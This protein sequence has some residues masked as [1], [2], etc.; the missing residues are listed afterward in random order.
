MQNSEHDTYL[1]LLTNLDYL[2]LSQIAGELP[3][4]MDR[5]NR[6]EITTLDALHL[7][8]KKQAEY[9][10]LSSVTNKI[11]TAGFP[12]QRELKDFDFSFQPMVNKSQMY[13]LATLDFME[14]AENV[15]FIGSPGVGKTHLATALG[16]EAA[17]KGF[18]TYF[19]KAHDLLTRLRQSKDEN[20]LEASLRYYN[21]YKLIIVDE[22]GFLPIQK[23]DEKLLFQFIDRRYEKKSVI[24]TSNM[25]FSEW[26]ELFE[27]PT[28]ANAI[29]DRLLHH[30]H[31][32]TIV[33]D[34]YRTKDLIQT[35]VTTNDE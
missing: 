17:K 29:L 12:H 7:L 2:K 11:K 6:H 18:L 14:K 33:G 5:V 20:R 3:H 31:V 9:K 23:G 10:K 28:I 25:Q 34:S 21:R 32:I 8:I 26:G 24:V 19:I 22:L 1:A 4:V 35:E 16:M 30:S 15:I 27:D 13:D